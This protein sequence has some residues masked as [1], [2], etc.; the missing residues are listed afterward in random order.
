MATYCNPRPGL[1][2]LTGR[3][4]ARICFWNSS[5]SRRSCCAASLTERHL[6]QEALGGEKG[7]LIISIVWL[8]L[9][10]HVE[11]P[12]VVEKQ[13]F[14]TLMCFGGVIWFHGLF[15]FIYYAS[16]NM[17]IAFAHVWTADQFG[18]AYY[19]PDTCAWNLRCWGHQCPCHSC[20][21]SRDVPKRNASP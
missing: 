5:L 14:W 4:N 9:W 15:M 19:F 11:L 21:S 16:F 7:N 17:N 1:W 3:L 6:V 8:C 12:G 10:H 2:H 13:A 18:F 20:Q